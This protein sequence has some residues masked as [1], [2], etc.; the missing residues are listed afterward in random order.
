[1]AQY[2]TLNSNQF[3]ELINA[4]ENSGGGGG[5]GGGGSVTFDELYSVGITQ[6]GT[7]FTLSGNISDYDI[8]IISLYHSSQTYQNQWVGQGI[9]IASQLTQDTVMWI[10][11]GNID[12]SVQL[13]VVS[14]NELK[15]LQNNLGTTVKLVHGIKF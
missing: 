4:I 5:G 10:T 12:R 6:T 8:I 9:Y 1:M 13:Q 14:D 7:P 15:I 2:V 11:G 3:S